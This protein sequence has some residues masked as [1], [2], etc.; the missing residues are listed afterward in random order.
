MQFLRKNTLAA[1]LS[2]LSL[3][4]V[5]QQPTNFQNLFVAREI[6]AAYE[7]GTRSTD[8]KPGPAYWQNRSEYKIRVNLD[9]QTGAI[10]GSETVQYVN[11]SPNSIQNLVI[12]LYPNIFNKGNA[13]D[14]RN[15]DPADLLDDD[16]VS[17]PLVRINGQ[18]V[19]PNIQGTNAILRIPGGLASK[20]NLK[21][22]VEWGYKI[23]AKSHIREGRYFETSYMVAY[24]YPQIAVYDDIDG[25]DVAQY[26]GKEEFYNDFSNFDVEVTVPVGHLV[27][28]TGVWQNPDQIL[29]AEILDRYRGSRT[30]E[31][32]VNVVTAA[33]REKGGITKAKIGRAHV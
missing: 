25:W 1:A 15:V 12:R 14:P 29:S 33:D 4:A 22:E 16:A 32:I 18:D 17:L 21:L 11:E 10:T 6:Q 5:A 23:P 19:K 9:P 24:W 28:A 13:R 30:S 8:G 2:T 27:W 20:Q 31:Q 26:T 3:G 7:K